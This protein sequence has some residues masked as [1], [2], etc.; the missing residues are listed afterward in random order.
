[1]SESQSLLWDEHREGINEGEGNKNFGS[2]PFPSRRSCSRRHQMENEKRMTDEL[3][4]V[5][6]GLADF[7]VIYGSLHEDADIVFADSLKDHFDSFS[8]DEYV[9][10][11]A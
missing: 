1:M 8:V 5:A 3:H 2:Y 6:E 10:E 9:F 7:G 4:Y 11:L